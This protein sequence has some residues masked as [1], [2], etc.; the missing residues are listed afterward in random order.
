MAKLP[1][2]VAVLILVQ[3]APGEGL[4]KVLAAALL[5]LRVPKVLQREAIVREVRLTA[6]VAPQGLHVAI[7]TKV[8]VR[9]IALLLVAIPLLPVVARVAVIPQ[10]VVVVVIIVVLLAPQVVAVAL[11]VAEDK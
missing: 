9:P 7:L 10:V 1:L 2:H 8:H 3:A 4:T 6:V 11:L 5:P